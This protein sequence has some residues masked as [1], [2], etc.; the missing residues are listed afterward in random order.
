[1]TTTLATEIPFALSV[2]TSVDNRCYRVEFHTA[3]DARAFM[4]RTDARDAELN[5]EAG[6]AHTWTRRYHVYEPADLGEGWTD[7]ALNDLFP[8]KECPHGLSADLCEDPINHY[9]P[10]AVAR[11]Y[12]YNV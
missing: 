3:A 6:T 7:E 10:D 2:Y 12:G 5:V 11:A 1:M 4:E 9:L 8:T